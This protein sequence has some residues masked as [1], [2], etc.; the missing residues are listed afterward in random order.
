MKLS[1]LTWRSCEGS[2]RVIGPLQAG[3]STRYPATIETPVWLF[4]FFSFLFWIRTNALAQRN[5]MT[6]IN[7]IYNGFWCFELITE[8]NFNHRLFVEYAV[9]LVRFTLGMVIK[10]IAA[11]IP[12]YLLVSYH[13][14]CLMPCLDLN[15]LLRY[16]SLL[17]QVNIFRV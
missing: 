1:G 15:G 9:L 5:W 12:R 3:R 13:H 6:S 17:T 8:R 11:V 16:E 2:K 4:Y 7:Y 10:R 14:F